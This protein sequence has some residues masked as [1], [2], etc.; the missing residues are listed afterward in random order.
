MTSSL[1][2]LFAA[3]RQIQNQ[4]D[5]GISEADALRSHFLPKAGEYFTATRS[6]IFFFDS[7]S[8]A[9]RDQISVGDRKLDKILQTGLSI[10][11]NPV[12]RYLVERHTP[13]HEA[14]LVSPK[15]WKMICPRPDHYHVMAG[16]IVSQGQL[17]G[18]IGFTRKQR[19]TAFNT[20]NL[21][22]LSAICLHLSTWTT[23][24][25]LP[26][27]SLRSNSLA[28]RLNQRL[29][30]RELE[31]ASLVAL[32][33]T[34]AEIGKELWITENSVKQALKRMFRKLEVSSRVELVT[35]LWTTLNLK[36]ESY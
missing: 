36:S 1:Q 20:Q 7:L 32:G 8:Q 9:I 22:D 13:V 14:L 30:S 2:L 35:Q 21:A 15:V 17:V 10:E 19:M 27:Q 6:G 28:E 34:N 24:V 12:V 11:H 31:I 18:V 29:T 26:Q 4:Q 16:P 3:I 23:T 5:M 33:R 25:S